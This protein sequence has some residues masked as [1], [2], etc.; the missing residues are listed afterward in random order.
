MASADEL[1]GVI[2]A[3]PTPFT[4]DGR[5][6]DGDALRRIVRHCLDGSVHGLMTTGGTGEFPHLSREERRRVAEIVSSETAG[7]VPVY[8]GT[9]ACS[10]WEAIALIEDAAA[11]GADAAI[12]T[13]PFYFP[14]PRE[15]LHRHFADV[16]AASPVPIVVYNNPLYTGMD[17]DPP[18][19]AE[20]MRLDNVIGLKQSNA[21]L[22]ALV[23]AIR[24]ADGT[25]R[26]L[27][28]GID[29]QFY[30]ALCVGARGIW[31]TAAS[32]VPAQMVR[33]YELMVAGDHEAA[34]AQHELLQ[35]L[36]RFLEYDPGYVSPTKEA[37]TMMGISAGPVRRPLPDFPEPERP[38]LREALA[39]LG[40]LDLAV[41]R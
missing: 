16:A 30:A 39:A 26:S 23:E 1:R 36:N 41:T 31:S 21:D 33:L 32:I 29:S 27:C 34:R 9:A 5:D 7:A 24:L 28:T 25:G 8:A 40:A 18:L 3:I 19:I 10:T 37:L 38:A 4:A 14:I 15:C 2:P 22:G 35:P 13:P 20:L 12:L 17:L 6:L 11:A